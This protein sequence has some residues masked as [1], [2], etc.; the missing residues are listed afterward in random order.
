VRSLIRYISP[1]LI[2]G[3]ILTFFYHTSYIK[4]E[5]VKADS[6]LVKTRQAKHAV[7]CKIEEKGFSFFRDVVA[8]IWPALK[9][10]N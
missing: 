9:S 5:I 4:D 6:C 8:N 3:L 10:L 7:A 1:L 2:G